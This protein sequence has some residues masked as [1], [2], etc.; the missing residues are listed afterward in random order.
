MGQ[1]TWQYFAY[2]PVA[3]IARH[4]AQD[5]TQ[6]DQDLNVDVQ[7]LIGKE[8][9]GVG[10]MDSEAATDHTADDT[11]D[12]RSPTGCKHSRSSFRGNVGRPSSVPHGKKHWVGV[13]RSRDSVM[14]IISPASRA[15]LRGVGALSNAK[16]SELFNEFRQPKY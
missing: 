2:A 6:H 15:R 16:R 13:Q 9:A 1:S 5:Q 7:S 12:V 8:A 11:R 10:R 3:P 4:G 14:N